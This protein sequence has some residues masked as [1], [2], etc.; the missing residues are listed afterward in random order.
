MLGLLSPEEALGS[1]CS[2]LGGGKAWVCPGLLQSCASQTRSFLVPF[3]E[4]FE[5]ACQS[6]GLAAQR[7]KKH[8]EADWSLTNHGEELHGLGESRVSQRMPHQAVPAQWIQETML[9]FSS[10]ISGHVT[11]RVMERSFN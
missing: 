9:V 8:F 11:G 10:V 3:G 2:Q 5:P 1:R 4:W 7:T 6:Q